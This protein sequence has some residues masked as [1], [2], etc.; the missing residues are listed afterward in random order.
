M[1]ELW[2]TLPDIPRIYT[3]V[4]QWSACVVYANYLWRSGR[5][6]LLRRLIILGIG[7]SAL[8]AIHL[9]ADH[10]DIVWWVPGMLASVVAMSGIIG[11]FCRMQPGFTWHLTARAFVLAEF[12]QSLAWQ[13]VVWFSAD[14]HPASPL[15]LGI[16]FAVYTAAFAIAF[17]AEKRHYGPEDEIPTVSHA[18]T[19]TSLAIAL[20]TFLMSNL[21]FLTIL[22]PFSGRMGTEVFYI[23]TLVDLCG[24]VALYA[25]VERILEGRMAAELA[26]IEATL[27]AQHAQYLQSKAEIEAIG[28]AHHDLKHHIAL[29]RAELDPQRTVAHFEELERS[30]GEIGQ[31][32][33]TGSPV[34]DI[35][36]S[37]KA[38][39]CQAAG[40][41]FTAVADG[42]LLNDM[43]SIDV[44]T[45]FGNALDNAIEASMRVSDPEKRLITLALHSQGSMTVLRVENWFDG[46]LRRNEDGELATLKPQ[47]SGHGIGVK[48]IRWTARTYGGEVTTH[49]SGNWFTLVVL[50]P[51]TTS[52]PQGA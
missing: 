33:H 22:T 44:A 9:C 28:R 6:T 20:I 8:I 41:T 23:R 51:S 37:S 13:L 10:L 12:V 7:L 5:I 36:L 52:G 15:A 14:P 1:H 31:Q 17:Y 45:L 49:I 43:S 38:S 34:L 39:T 4:A 32:F 25:Q 47:R 30:I 21:S 16:T 3:A 26:S 18:E 35:V 11:S 40:I 27:K 46:R 29:I 48:S 42:T 50:L 24:V 2:E 19:W